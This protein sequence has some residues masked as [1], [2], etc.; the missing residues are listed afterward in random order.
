MAGAQF[1][2]NQPK[3]VKPIMRCDTAETVGYSESRVL[4]SAIHI[5]P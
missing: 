1:K 3:F 5:H 2:Q 4:C